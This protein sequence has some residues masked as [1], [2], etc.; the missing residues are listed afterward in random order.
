MMVKKNVHQK[1][2]IPKPTYGLFANEN[3]K[4]G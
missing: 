4:N 3:E 2:P 1:L